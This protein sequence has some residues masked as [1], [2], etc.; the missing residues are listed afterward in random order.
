MLRKSDIPNVGINIWKNFCS[1]T[2]FQDK[3]N[4][5]LFFAKQLSYFLSIAFLYAIASNV[6][7]QYT[8][9]LILEDPYEQFN[10]KLNK[11]SV[12]RKL[13]FHMYYPFDTSV[14]DGHFWYV[15]FSQIYMEAMPPC[16]FAGTN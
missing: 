9:S 10:V 11:T 16:L 12:Y 7:F 14:S 2:K 15:F 8:F 6:S 13:P 1:S 3:M 5:E 4:E